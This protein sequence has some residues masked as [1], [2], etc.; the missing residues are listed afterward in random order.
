[1]EGK[2]TNKILNEVS[3]VLEALLFSNRAFPHIIIP[4]VQI[5]PFY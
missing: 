5:V 2:N 1:M 4:T 3:P